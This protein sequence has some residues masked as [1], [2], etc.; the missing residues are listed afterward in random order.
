M[1]ISEV[2]A[3]T[4]ARVES[5][6]HW[7]AQLRELIDNIEPLGSFVHQ[8]MLMNLPQMMPHVSVEKVG[9]LGFPLFHLA[10]DALIAVSSKAPY[11]KMDQTLFDIDVRDAWQIDATKVTFGGGD[12]W[13]QY[14]TETVRKHCGHLGITK[15]RYDRLGIQANLYKM[16]IYEEGGHF[17]K[18]RDTE[19]ERNMFGTLII[20]L[21]TSEGFTGGEFTVTHQ[22]TTKTLNLSARS[23]NEFCSVSFYA[24]CEHELHP[25]TSGKRVCLVYNLVAASAKP[26]LLPVHDVNCNMDTEIK[27][28]QIAHNWKTNSTDSPKVHKIGL[29][30]HHKYSHQ[31]IG[32]AT[33]KGQDEFMLATFRKAK[34]SDGTRLFQ[35]DLLLMERYNYFHPELQ[36]H[37]YAETTKPLAVIVENENGSYSK[38][39]LFPKS[40]EFSEVRC[41]SRN[42]D[43]PTIIEDPDWGMYCYTNKGFWVMKGVV[44]DDNCINKRAQND[45]RKEEKNDDDDGSVTDEY[46]FS[47]PR[48]QKMFLSPYAVETNEHEYT[49]NEGGEME[50]WYYSAAIILSPYSFNDSGTPS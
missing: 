32:I 25:I 38:K 8:Y 17:L 40:E 39:Q 27:L 11:G 9:R 30:L 21:P 49:G 28:R 5:S 47:I 15:D 33:L 44:L 34:D 35:A 19:K 48:N 1:E 13:N 42:T 45:D 36:D 20:Q 7:S 12:V 41:D 23:D 31:N 4:T 6:W 10:V 29:P 18:H 14:L 24:D 43:K 16:L 3:P 37:S 50:T 22:G 46:G 26:N 2:Q